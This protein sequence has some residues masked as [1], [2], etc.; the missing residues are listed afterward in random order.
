MCVVFAEPARTPQPGEGAFDDPAA[1]QHLEAVERRGAF[2]D[3]QPSATAGTQAADPIDQRTGVTAVGPDTPQ[4][5]EAGAQRGEQQ[6]GSIPILHVGGMDADE[7]NQ[8]QG[9]DQKVSLSSCHLLASIVST[10]STLLS[11]SHTLRI[12]DRSRGGLFLPAW[13]R[14]ASRSA[15]LSRAHTPCFFQWAK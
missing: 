5:A 14:T 1:G 15:S 6:A 8:S 12:K 7:Q 3:L 10:N 2:N 4:P 9:I 11:C 13:R